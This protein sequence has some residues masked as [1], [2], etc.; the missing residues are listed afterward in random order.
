MGRPPLL[1][2][3]DSDDDWVPPIMPLTIDYD[4]QDSDQ[5]SDPDEQEYLSYEILNEN[6][7]ITDPFFYQENI[8]EMEVQIYKPRLFEPGEWLVDLPSFPLPS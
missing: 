6:N 1:D 3:K 4:Y 8:P 2:S 7:F 5:E